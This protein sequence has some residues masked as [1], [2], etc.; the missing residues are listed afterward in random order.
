MRTFVKELW[1]RVRYTFTVLR[2]GCPRV[3]IPDGGIAK[4]VLFEGVGVRISKGACS[5]VQGCTV[6][7]RGLVGFE[8]GV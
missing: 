1:S 7:A 3:T 4:N 6:V 5:H 2:W 8:F